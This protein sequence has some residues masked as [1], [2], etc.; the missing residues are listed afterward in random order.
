[1]TKEIKKITEKVLLYN[2]EHGSMSIEVLFRDETFWMTQKLLSQL[3]QVDRSV[4]SKHI[5]NIFASEELIEDSVCAKIAHTASDGKIYTSSYFNLDV[6]IAVGYRV[7]SKEATRFRKW[8][9]KIL[10]DYIIKGF[11]LDDEM[12]K[13]GRQFGKDYFDELLE[14]I[15]AIR[16]SERLFYLKL[17]DLFAEASYDYNKSSD[18]ARQFYS[19]TQNKLHWAITGKTAAEIVYERADAKK[20][21]MGLTSWK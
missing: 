7:N 19:T 3:F 16:A 6:I 12:L 14:R 1:M 21:N 8:S 9:T 11:V 15:R 17:T 13:N 4:I 2:D 10:R 20:P 5:K 18:T